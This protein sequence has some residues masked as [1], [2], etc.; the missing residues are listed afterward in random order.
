MLLD[1][2]GKPLYQGSGDYFDINDPEA[3]EAWR[4]ALATDYVGYE[5]GLFSG[6]ALVDPHGKRVHSASGI[7][8]RAQSAFVK[9]ITLASPETDAIIMILD[10]DKEI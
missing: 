2:Y 8:I 3:V 10:D 4:R 5:S 9:R 7:E 1:Q 6:P